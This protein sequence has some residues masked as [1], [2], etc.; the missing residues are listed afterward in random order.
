MYDK[1]KYMQATERVDKQA[2]RETKEAASSAS[3]QTGG[4]TTTAFD[5]G[6]GRQQLVGIWWTCLLVGFPE[7]RCLPVDSV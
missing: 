4:T 6:G 1:Q 2:A 5:F 3:R 7:V